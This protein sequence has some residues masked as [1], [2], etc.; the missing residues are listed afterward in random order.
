M[1]LLINSNWFGIDRRLLHCDVWARAIKNDTIKNIIGWNE[2]EIT[3][4][5]S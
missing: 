5:Q 3:N 1:A 4:W 2:V